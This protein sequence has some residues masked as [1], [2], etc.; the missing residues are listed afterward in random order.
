MEIATK[1]TVGQLERAISQKVQA[2]YKQHLGHQPKKVSCQMFD[3]KVVIVLED[4]I[5]QPEKILAAAGRGG[6]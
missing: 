2:A 1:Q 5:T 4:S 3:S 6:Y